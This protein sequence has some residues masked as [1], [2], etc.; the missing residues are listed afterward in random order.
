MSGNEED[1]CINIIIKEREQIDE[2]LTPFCAKI[3]DNG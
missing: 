3:I 1:S 2:S